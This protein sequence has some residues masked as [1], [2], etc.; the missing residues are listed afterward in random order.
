MYVKFKSLNLNISTDFLNTLIKA[1]KY[2]K[3][4]YS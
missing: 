2:I 3:S 1:Y 4:D